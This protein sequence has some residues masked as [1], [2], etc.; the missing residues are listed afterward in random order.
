MKFKDSV[1]QNIVDPVVSTKLTNAV[2]QIVRYNPTHNVADVYVSTTDG[3]GMTLRNVPIQLAVTG[4]HSS[5]LQ[6]DDYVYI[7]YNNGSIYQPIII[8]K[9]DEYYATTTKANENHLTC[10]E[11]ITIQ[12]ELEGDIIPS[13]DTWIDTENTNSFKY[14]SYRNSS[15]IENLAQMTENIGK[16]K[17][18]EVGLFNP[19]ASNVVKL[20]DDGSI[21]IFA[22]TNIGIKINPTNKTIEILGNSYTKSNNWSVIS[23]NVDI[24][25]NDNFNIRA[26]TL[27]IKADNITVNGEDK[28]V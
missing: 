16:F 7:Q 14:Y 25:A 24:V 12:E 1:I 22:D 9:S 28:D 4:L 2:G 15:A 10:G 27:N 21:S 17:G 3:T 26:K 13:S 19:V 11:L 23:N 18:Q 5:A 20:L 8:G 6:T